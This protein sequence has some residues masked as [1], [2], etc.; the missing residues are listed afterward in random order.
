MARYTVKE[1]VLNILHMHKGTYYSGQELA[2]ALDVSR[3]AV[4]KAINKLREEGYKIE[5]STRNGYAMASDTDILNVN[6]I[7]EGLAGE[8]RKFYRVTCVEKIDSTNIACRKLG[9]DGE[10]EGACVVASKQTAGRG[11]RGRRFESPDMT[12]VYLSILLRPDMPI[13]DSVHITTAAAVAA[14]KACETLEGIDP[15]DVSIKWVNDLFIRDRKFAGILTEASISVENGK[16]DYAV[17]GIGFNLSEPVGGWPEELSGIAGS[18][19]EGEYPVGCR[20]QLV[21]AFLQ[22]FYQV[23]SSLPDVT[24]LDEYRN[25]QLAIGK[26]VK[27]LE[28]DGSYRMADVVNVDDDCHLLVRF[29]GEEYIS[30]LD[31]GEISIRC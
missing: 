26:T 9:E 2:E 29:E 28:P 17:M 30:N 11:R 12:G 3:T 18:L 31:S 24:Y 21:S 16:L 6:E 22:E 1:Q 15:G 14:A 27:V 5:G 25:R 7:S 8:A 19:Y 13:S 10:P 20:N 4:W 23:Y